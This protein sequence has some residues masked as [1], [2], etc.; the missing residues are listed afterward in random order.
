MIEVKDP[1]GHKRIDTLRPFCIAQYEETNAQ[2]RAY[3]KYLKR[4]KMEKEYLAALPD[5]SVWL[6]EDLQNG[7][8]QML[9][10]NY[11]R[12]K[13][14]D[15]YPVVGVNVQQVMAYASWKTD[16][17]NE[18]IFIR[19]GLLDIDTLNTDT[20]SS[21]RT[22]AYLS[23]RYHPLADKLPSFDEVKPERDIR[24]EDGIFL[25]ALR[26]PTIDEWQLAARAIGD[27]HNKYPKGPKQYS[28]GKLYKINLFSYFTKRKKH[29][30]TG[31][32]KMLRWT[33]DL[34]P[35]WLGRGNKNRI[36]SM[37]GNVSE[38]CVSGNKAIGMGG[39]WKKGDGTYMAE[40]QKDST[41]KYKIKTEIPITA[42]ELSYRAANLGFRLAS[43]LLC[44]FRTKNE[45]DSAGF[46]PQYRVY[47]RERR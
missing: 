13:Q 33:M 16:R 19:E 14:F 30:M 6:K 10:Q 20:A 43:T 3:L 32:C 37:E 42:H 36:F 23:G 46:I 41:V 4:F 18:M 34:E 26:L 15:D 38:L 45:A 24:M 8:G 11:F 5:T 47:K 27:D 39:S 2:Y 35:A 44:V 12:D 28:F 17:M 25:P 7:T 9:F 31:T 21:F 22:E 29:W 40:F 1:V